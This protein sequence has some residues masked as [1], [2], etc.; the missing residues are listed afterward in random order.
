VQD[1]RAER[2]KKL[3]EQVGFVL[4]N[5]LFVDVFPIDGYPESKVEAILTKIITGIAKCI[6]RFRCM[7]F[8]E[9]TKNGKKVWLAG[10]FFGLLMPWMTQKRCLN[11]CERRLT[12]HGF[13][14]SA[15]NGRTC[16][17]TNLFRRAP[18][19]REAWG[20]PTTHE[21][22]D[23][24]IMLPEDVDAHLRNEYYKWDYMELPPEF[25]Q[26]PSHSCLYNCP[27]RLGPK[28]KGL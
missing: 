23:T 11:L 22:H 27:W 15:F 18:L 20:R 17:T 19:R 13:D 24:Q 7:N 9:Q 26:R 10:L 16:S 8:A 25:M 21:F 1:T 12:K 5:G 6:L 14:E 28:G 3:E 2:V 4:S